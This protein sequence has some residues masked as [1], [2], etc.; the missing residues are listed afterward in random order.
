MKTLTLNISDI[1][2]GTTGIEGVGDNITRSLASRY[3]FNQ[4]VMG[5]QGPQTITITVNAGIGAN[6]KAVGQAIQAELNKYLRSNV[7]LA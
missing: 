7:Q 6:G 1:M 3:L 5:G 4:Q 2:K